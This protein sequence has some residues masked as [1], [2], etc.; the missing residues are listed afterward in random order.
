MHFVLIKHLSPTMQSIAYWSSA[1]V[2]HFGLPKKASVLYGLPFT[3]P[4]YS[5]NHSQ[6][7]NM[8]PS[9]AL[10]TSVELTIQSVH[11]TPFLCS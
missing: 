10:V 6:E 7:H 11:T 8:F 1:Y 5:L 3:L 2:M 9:K 4:A